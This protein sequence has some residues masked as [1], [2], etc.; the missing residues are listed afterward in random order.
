ME[1]AASLMA[2]NR[3]VGCRPGRAQVAKHVFP[4][5]LSLSWLAMGSATGRSQG[6]EPLPPPPVAET[7][8]IVDC[9]P[10]ED[11]PL[12]ASIIDTRPRDLSNEKRLVS[13]GDLPPDCNLRLDQQAIPSTIVIDREG[14]VAGRALGK[15]SESSLRGLIE[16]LLEVEAQ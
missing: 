5:L 4:L 7:T 6:Q 3:R 11:L 15:V 1:A 2:R 14:R 16:P 13:V 12:S 9:Q 10:V 8:E